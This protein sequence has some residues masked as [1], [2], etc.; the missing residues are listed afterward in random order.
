MAELTDEQIAQVKAIY[1]AWQSVDGGYEDI[2]ELCAAVT[3]EGEGGIRDKGYTL[4]PSKYIEFIDR[5]LGIE[6]ESEMK[7][8]QTEMREVMIAEKASQAMLED[9]FRGIGYGID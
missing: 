6:Y 8:I 4:T 7:R 1:N 5:D 9:A 2:P 3:L